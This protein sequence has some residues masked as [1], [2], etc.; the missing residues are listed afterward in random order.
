MFVSETHATKI[1]LHR[2][3]PGN[4]LRSYQ[5]R[6]LIEELEQEELI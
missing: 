4:E 3:H 1:M 5:I 6:Q 2:P